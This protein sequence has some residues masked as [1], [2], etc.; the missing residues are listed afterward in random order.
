MWPYARSI[1]VWNSKIVNHRLFALVISVCFS[2]HKWVRVIVWI[3]AGG[4]VNYDWLEGKSSASA[5]GSLP[6]EWMAWGILLFIYFFTLFIYPCLAIRGSLAAFLPDTRTS[7]LRCHSAA[8]WTHAGSPS[9]VGWQRGRAHIH[10]LF[11]FTSTLSL[12]LSHRRFCTAAADRKLRLLTSDLQDKHEVKVA[13]HLEHA[14]QKFASPFLYISLTFSATGRWVDCGARKITPS[15][16]KKKK[17]KL[18]YWSH[19]FLFT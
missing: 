2:C 5:Q 18:I 1:C 4:G 11:I 3:T 12:P 16:S 8:A 13:Q 14:G 17:K 19:T 7:I 6:R 15:L 10:A 9:V